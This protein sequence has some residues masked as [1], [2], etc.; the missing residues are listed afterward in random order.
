MLVVRCLSFV[1]WPLCCLSIFDLR[2]LITPLVSSNS[3]YIICN[4]PVYLYIYTIFFIVKNCRH[5]YIQSFPKMRSVLWSNACSEHTFLLLGI[6]NG[7]HSKKIVLDKTLLK[8]ETWCNLSFYWKY[9]F[10]APMS[11]CH[12]FA[13]VVCM[14]VPR[15][16]F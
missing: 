8:P 5:T 9:I 6:Q 7:H 3:S 1:F 16:K 14:F 10:L 15:E 11:H 4:S 12:N 13:S 2:I